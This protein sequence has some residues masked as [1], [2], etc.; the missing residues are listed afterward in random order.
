MNEQLRIDWGYLAKL[1]QGI[2]Q[3]EATGIRARWEFGCYLRDNVPRSVGGRGKVGPLQAIAAELNVSEQELR[4]RRQF[5][6]AYPTEDKLANALA[7]FGSWFAIVNDGLAEK[8]ERQPR[9]L[10]PAPAL[11]IDQFSVIYCDPPWRYEHAST[12]S[13]AIELHYPTMTLDEIKRLDVPAAPAAALFLWATSP[14]LA[15][16]LEV[17]DAWGFGYRTCMVWVKDK[18]GMG[19]YVR[20][21]HE[22]LL[23]G[24]R[25]DMPLP[26][27]TTLPSSVVT[28]PRGRH[29]EKPPEFYDV[30]EAMYPGYPKVELFARAA[31]EG[32][33]SWGNEVAE[34]AA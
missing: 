7:T 2:G 17:V 27:E 4:F 31:R 9:T 16:A 8:Q 20:Q 18:I 25:G 23:I 13:R 1:E 15:E 10:P 33:Q 34:V 6:E 28:A 12:P 19:Y 26:D 29:S 21:Q 5:S 24:R 14:K 32:W 30:I 3:S 11:P 22:L